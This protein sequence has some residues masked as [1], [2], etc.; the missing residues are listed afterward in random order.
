MRLLTQDTKSE[1]VAEQFVATKSGAYELW[2]VYFCE[3]R[4]ARQPKTI[5]PHYGAMRLECIGEGRNMKLEGH[6]WIDGDD[7]QLRDGSLTLT[8]RRDT[9][10]DDYDAAKAAYS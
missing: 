6:Y 9:R 4:A 8:D 3:T 5:I 10:Y 7:P 1:L 2:A